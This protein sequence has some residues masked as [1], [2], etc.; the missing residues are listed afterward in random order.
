LKSKLLKLII[1]AILLTTAFTP[2]ISSSSNDKNFLSF[3]NLIRKNTNESFDMIIIA[4]SCYQSS[5]QPL[6]EHK[7]NR[8]ISTNF[9][10]LDDIYSSV[11]FNLQGRD[12]QEKIKYFIKEAIE[13]WEITYVLFIGS[14]S[15]IPVRL[16]FNN[17]NYSG[18]NEPSFV[19]E[20]YYADIYNENMEFSSWDTDGDEIYGEWDGIVAEDRPINLAPDVCLGRLACVN[21]KE[22][23]HVV[24]KIIDYEKKPANPKWFKNMVV[25]GG[26]TYEKFE[27]YEG[28]IYNQQAVDAMQDFN[29][30][31]LWGS[32]GKLK[33]GWDI[34]KEINK[35]CGFWYL[36]GHGN[37]QLWV[38]YNPEGSPIGKF[39]VYHTLFLLNKNKLPVCLVGGCHN[40]RFS[41]NTYKFLGFLNRLNWMKECWSWRLVSK[42]YGGSIATLG[43]TGLSWYSAEYDGEG[44]NWLNV[45]FF[46]EY[47]NDTVILGQIWKNALNLYLDNFPI[48]WETPS[49]GFNSINAKTVQEWTLLGDPSLKIGGYSASTQNSLI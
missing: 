27:G 25:V 35:G 47:A 16:C 8:G 46:K 1:I 45:Q 4:P 32:N 40:S 20:L 13:N 7:N 19:S 24:R 29:A 15:Q 14:F 33:S 36:T 5:I 11:L 22:V 21:E 48:D 38:T 41:V 23:K 39:N 6:I 44:L 10:S 3:H 42:P 9:V 34:V 12:D 30:V 18:F 37:T 26:D 43:S 28:E 17:D 31:K 49:G 2:I